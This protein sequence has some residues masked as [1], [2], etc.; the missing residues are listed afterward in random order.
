M[1]LFRYDIKNGAL[2]V[3][4]RSK[5]H[6]SK[7]IVRLRRKRLEQKCFL[8]VTYLSPSM[9]GTSYLKYT[10]ECHANQAAMSSTYIK[11]LPR[12]NLSIPVA[13]G[14]STTNICT[15]YQVSKVTCVTKSLQH[16]ISHMP[17]TQLLG[18]QSQHVGLKDGRSFSHQ[19]FTSWG[20]RWHYGPN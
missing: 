13:Y 8:G 10:N 20:L 3:G 11:S 1:R 15:I 7:N 18:F 19:A 17:R 2:H 9:A 12:P 5:C 14:L 4:D 6:S 16:S